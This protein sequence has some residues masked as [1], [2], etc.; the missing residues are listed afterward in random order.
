M[1]YRAVID[2]EQ[3]GTGRD[4]AG[5]P[6]KAGWTV[7]LSQLRGDILI[8]SGAEANRAD[9]PV[10]EVRASIRIRWRQDAITA[11]M[12]VRDGTTYY[13]I[14]AVQRDERYRRHIDLVCITGAKR[15]P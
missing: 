14:R 7:F 3:P 2:I 5:Q 11:G 12:R 10:S 1:R 15:G 8:Q 9:A 13:D 4:A 6:I